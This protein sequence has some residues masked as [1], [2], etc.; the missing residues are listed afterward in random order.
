MVSDAISASLQGMQT[1]RV[2]VNKAAESIANYQIEAQN[3]KNNIQQATQNYFEA[4]ANVT[5]PSALQ[6]QEAP[7][8]NSLSAT[9]EPASLEQD[10]IKLIEATN[11]YEANAAAYNMAREAEQSVL[12]IL[13]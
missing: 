3:Q 9:V 8:E 2:A 5:P 10:V 1:Q 4:G 12:D 7:Q 13:S 11:L 6:A